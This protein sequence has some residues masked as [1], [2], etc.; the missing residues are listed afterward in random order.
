[1]IVPS[2][3]QPTALLLPPLSAVAPAGWMLEQLLIEANGLAGY[4][5]T[6]SFPGADRVNTSLWTNR[7]SIPKDSITQWLPYWTNGI[8]PLVGL[9]ESAGASSRVQSGVGARIDEAMRYVL[10]HTNK[11][12]GW[13]GPYSNEPGDTNGHGLWDPL[14]MLRSL[15]QYSQY[16][17]GLER[18]IAAACIAH[19]VA[20][21]RM[22]AADPII[23]WAATRWPTYVVS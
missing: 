23:K 20:E 14:N 15:L 6:S 11:T 22:I 9:L 16:R 1:M 8:V 19:L 12:N 7:S 18:P 4:L 13:I 10:A 21:T 2:A 17:R 5:S 3:L